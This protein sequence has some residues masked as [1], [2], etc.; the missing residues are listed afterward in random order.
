MP[1]ARKP[2]TGMSASPMIR[3]RTES[4]AIDWASGCNMDGIPGAFTESPST[5]VGAG[6]A[7]ALSIGEECM[8][9]LNKLQTTTTHRQCKMGAN[10]ER[11]AAALACGGMGW[12][13][14]S[15]H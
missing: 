11:A 13:A 14:I 4:E 6:R 12:R 2:T 10:I 9:W 3:V 8:K 1:L 5:P 15:L 7:A